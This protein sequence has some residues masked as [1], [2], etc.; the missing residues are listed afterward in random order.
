M[1]G[2]LEG[3]YIKLEVIG[4][5]NLKVPSPSQRFPQSIVEFQIA[6]DTIFSWFWPN[7]RSDILTTQVALTNLA[8]VRLKGYTRKDLQDI[9]SIAS[10][11]H[12]ALALR[13][14]DHPDH[15]LSLYYL[16]EALTWCYSKEH[17]SIYIHESAQLYCKLL[18]F[19]PAAWGTYL[20]SIAAGENGVNYVIRQCSSLPIDASGG[21][22]FALDRLS[23]ALRARFQHR[24]SI[25]DIDKSIQIDREAVSLT[26]SIT[27]HDLDDAISIH[28]EAL[29]LRPVGHKSRHYSLDN[30][31]LALFTRFD[32]RDDINGAISL[33]REALTLCPPGNLH[34]VITLNNLALALKTRCDKLDVNEDV[35]GA[36]DLYRDSLQLEQRGH[37]NRH[38]TLCNLSLA[39]C[40]CFTQTQKNVDVKEAIQL[41]QES[42]AILP[43]LHP[44]RY[45]SYMRLQEAYLSRYRVQYQS[46]DSSL[47]VEDFSIPLK[48]FR[49]ASRRLLTGLAK[50][51]S[52][53][54][55]LLSKH[56]KYADCPGKETCLEDL[57][58]CSYMP[59]L[60]ALIRSGRMMKSCVPPSF[61]VI[62]QGQPGAGES[63]A[64]LAV[65]SELELVRK[66]VPATAN[67]TTSMA[68]QQDPRQPYNSHFVMRDE[69]LMLLDIMEKDIPHAESAFLSACHT[70][71][72]DEETPGEVIHLAV[73]LQFSRFKNVIVNHATHAVKTKVPLEQRMVFIHIGV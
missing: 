28:E 49:I 62:G 35:N 47:A 8:W 16:T 72:G 20:H 3:R 29:R 39:L 1:P 7:V 42:L 18:P 4:G 5:E 59:T 64:L 21:V 67:H 52:I 19:R 13:L 58:I 32:Q 34:C 69:P 24:G 66:L 51:K 26:A 65:D 33:N 45:F 6:R 57:Y 30:L 68:T 14:Q 27:S 17:T 23:W 70:T 11:F 73:G 38:K 9:D 31:G 25:D 2:S 55:T 43:S 12:E 63:K 22:T 44:S 54:T 61:V 36:I 48:D 50:Q 53:D 71:V 40:S 46:V 56:T 10:L 60:S 37:P 41:C 15:P